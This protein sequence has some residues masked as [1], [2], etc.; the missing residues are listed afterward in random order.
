MSDP[1]IIFAMTVRSALIMLVR[2]IE[3]RYHIKA[4]EFSAKPQEIG[5][6]DTI[7]ALP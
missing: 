2:A 3:K 1:D 6:N 7:A 5:E 4:H